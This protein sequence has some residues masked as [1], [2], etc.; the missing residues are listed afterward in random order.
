MGS[1]SQY[2][3]I[4]IYIYR[5]TNQAN[6]NKSKLAKTIEFLYYTFQKS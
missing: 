6:I 5:Y 1:R 2:I 3:Y 4:Y